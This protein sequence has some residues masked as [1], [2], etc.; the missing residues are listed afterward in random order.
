MNKLYYDLYENNTFVKRISDKEYA[1]FWILDNFIKSEYTLNYHF[2]IV[3]MI[4]DDIMCSESIKI[5]DNKVIKINKYNNEFN[6]GNILLYYKSLLFVFLPLYNIISF[7]L[8][9]YNE[10]RN[11]FII[12]T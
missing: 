12:N 4:A 9:N 3:K 7:K 8:Y 6:T 1:L 10:Y 5:Y 11:N 2:D